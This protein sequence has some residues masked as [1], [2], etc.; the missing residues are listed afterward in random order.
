MVG[1]EL[2]NTVTENGHVARGVCEMDQGGNLVAINERTCIETT[3]DGIAYTEDDG[4]TWVGLEKDTIV[5]MNMWGFT[6]SILKELENKFPAFLDENLPENSLKCEYFLPSVVS[7]LLSEDKATVSVLTSK[8]KW[9]GVTYK[10]GKPV[11]VKAMK[12][13]VESGVYPKKLWE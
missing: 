2:E 4:A 8:D 5:S 1:Y 13:M 10:E 7:E 9:F 6:A 3:E 11:V 12:E